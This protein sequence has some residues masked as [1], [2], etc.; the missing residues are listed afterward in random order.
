MATT[1]SAKGKP[2]KRKKNVLTTGRQQQKAV[3]QSY[4]KEALEAALAEARQPNHQPFKA[5]AESHG[6]PLTTL[7]RHMTGKTS[8]TRIDRQPYLS[9]D[10]EDQIAGKIQMWHDKW[11]YVVQKTQLEAFVFSI[12]N[13]LQP[14]SR[15][16]KSWAKKG[17][18]A[19][20]N[21]GFL[22]RHP[23]ISHA[24]VHDLDKAARPADYKQFY[25]E[26]VAQMNAK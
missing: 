25:L 11:E 2:V 22:R 26:L 10:I 13:E 15:M 24:V 8:Y 3:R 6:V 21:R 20:W 23:N 16:V 12:A 5:I 4:P 17:V 19:K 7:H 14:D 1:R 9:R 18:S